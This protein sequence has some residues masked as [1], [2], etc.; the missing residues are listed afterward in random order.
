MSL[1]NAVRRDFPVISR[2]ENISL[3]EMDEKRR[4]Y[5]SLVFPAFFL[6]L[7]WLIHFIQVGMEWS[8]ISWGIYPLTLSGLKGI[9]FAPLIHADWKHLFDNSIPLFILSLALFYFY[10]EISYKVFFL[11][12]LISGILVWVFARQSYHI[13]ASGLIYG[14]AFFLFFSGII[15]RVR[16]LMAISLLVVFLYGSLVWGLL[17]FDY[18]ISW[19]GHISGAVTGII[20]AIIYRNEGPSPERPSWEEEEENE[21]EQE[22][23][24]NKVVLL[25][26]EKV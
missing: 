13:G 8:F 11:I 2:N 12:W 5:H 17:P 15:R 7:I 10:R 14:I 19:E 16:S 1:F 3:Q 18:K 25:S 26:E 21:D 24:S 4:F 9:L 20:L 22:T 6:L 23:L